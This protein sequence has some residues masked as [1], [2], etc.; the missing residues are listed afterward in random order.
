MKRL[1]LFLVRRR[2]RLKKNER[3][4]FTN[5]RTNAVYWFTDQALLKDTGKAIYPSNASLNWLLSDKCEIRR[6]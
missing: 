3:F 5:Q 6:I 1:I 2:L 4:Q